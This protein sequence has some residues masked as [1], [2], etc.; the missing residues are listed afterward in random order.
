MPTVELALPEIP[1]D[2]KIKQGGY[3]SVKRVLSEYDRRL[4]DN[5]ELNE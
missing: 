2:L 4:K 5:D 1:K 3:D